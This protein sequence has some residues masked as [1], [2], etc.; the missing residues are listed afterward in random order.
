MPAPGCGRGSRKEAIKRIRSFVEST[1]KS[2]SV[3]ANADLMTRSTAAKRHKQWDSFQLCPTRRKVHH[4]TTCLPANEFSAPILYGF[5]TYC[6]TRLP[7][8]QLDRLAAGNLT[9]PKTLAKPA[10][11]VRRLP[12]LRLHPFG[13]PVF[14]WMETSA[15]SSLPSHCP[16]LLF[17]SR[18][19][20]RFGVR[21]KTGVAQLTE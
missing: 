17:P 12:L 18:E 2:Q 6:R 7:E 13:S 10:G 9:R 11:A 15:D 21:R 3:D 1:S 14:P 4:F 16:F 19:R 5:L 20:R 8:A